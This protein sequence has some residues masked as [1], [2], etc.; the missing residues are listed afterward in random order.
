MEKL[1]EKEFLSFPTGLTIKEYLG[2][3][4]HRLQKVIFGQNL[5]SIQEVLVVI[6]LMA[7]DSKKV[8]IILLREFI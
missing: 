4:W 8:L 6:Y 5:L 1:M 3:I 2:M 7:K